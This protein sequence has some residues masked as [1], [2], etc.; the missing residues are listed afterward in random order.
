MIINQVGGGKKPT[1]TKTITSNGT[2]DVAGYANADVQVPTTAPAHYVEKTVDANGIL[3]NT[4]NPINTL[5]GVTDVDG[6]GCYGIMATSGTSYTGTISLDASSLTTISG[7][8]AFAY[9]LY[10]QK[11]HGSNQNGPILD[12]DFRNVET[13]S[14]LNAFAYFNDSPAVAGRVTQNIN[15]NSLS[16]ALERIALAEAN[17]F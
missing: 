1:G 5:S 3:K 7:E 12:I 10:G 9:A 6:Y 13:I 4:N 2:H 8:S 11:Y 15:F 17:F 16:I 14:G